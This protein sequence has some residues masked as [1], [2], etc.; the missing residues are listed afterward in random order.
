MRCNSFFSVC[1][2]E[3]FCNCSRYGREKDDRRDVF[4]QFVPGRYFNLSRMPG[5]GFWP[6]TIPAYEMIQKSITILGQIKGTR[7]K[8]S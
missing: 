7:L 6:G 2:G 3:T 1:L 5:Y 4:K 8:D